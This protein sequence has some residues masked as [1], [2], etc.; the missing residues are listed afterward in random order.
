MKH[1]MNDLP[2]DWRK[3]LFEYMQ[4]THDVLL[5]DS[6]MDE[7]RRIIIGEEN[8]IREQNAIINQH[9]AE[10]RAFQ[11]KNDMP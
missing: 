4:N 10:V 3:K 6:D 5:L 2:S 9:Y 11:I 1:W 8:Y 7:I